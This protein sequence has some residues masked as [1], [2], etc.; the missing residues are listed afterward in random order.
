[1][2]KKK[3]LLTTSNSAFH[4][5]GLSNQQQRLS[6][7]YFSFPLSGFLFLLGEC[8]GYCLQALVVYWLEKWQTGLS[9]S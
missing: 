3:F 2:L 5:K 6:A 1:M 8:H 9:T 7:E 4:R